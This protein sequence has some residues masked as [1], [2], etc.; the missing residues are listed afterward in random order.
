M[1][2]FDDIKTEDHKF[3]DELAEHFENLDNDRDWEH[4][5]AQNIAKR[6]HQI[7]IGCDQL[8]LYQ[9]REVRLEEQIEKKLCEVA[10]AWLTYADP[11]DSPNA[12]ASAIWLLSRRIREQGTKSALGV[13][14]GSLLAVAGRM[15]S[16]APTDDTGGNHGGI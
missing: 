8:A 10:E 2:L 15:G 14:L 1:G 16:K 6:L 7:A 12:I 9:Q 4:Q 13:G 11:A 5:E 3:L